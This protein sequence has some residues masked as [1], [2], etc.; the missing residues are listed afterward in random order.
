MK[1]F[2][3]ALR[4]QKLRAFYSQRLHSLGGNLSNTFTGNQTK[5]L[6]FFGN[7]LCDF[8]HITTHNDRQLIMRAFV[9]NRQ[10]DICEVNH[11]QI[12]RSGI[13]RQLL[14]QIN[15]FLLRTL[16]RSSIRS[17]QWRSMRFWADGFW[18][19]SRI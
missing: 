5:A 16:T 13:R 8:H 1:F 4:L 9:V 19:H 11:M 17:S 18:T 2:A 14:C 12:D 10:L 6:I 15:D 3:G 7:D